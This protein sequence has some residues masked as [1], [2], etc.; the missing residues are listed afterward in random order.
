MRGF[1]RRA[2]VLCLTVSFDSFAGLGGDSGE[3]RSRREAAGV[4]ANVASGRF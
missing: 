4:V 2:R 3:E 1:F